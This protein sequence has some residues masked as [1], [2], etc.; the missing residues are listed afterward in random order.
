MLHYDVKITDI[1]FSPGEGWTPFGVT[2]TDRIAWSRP[3]DVAVLA[4]P[5][6]LE[7]IGEA[8]ARLLEAVELVEPRAG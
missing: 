1:G 6:K 3:S 2:S 4:P 5:P 8:R 7:T